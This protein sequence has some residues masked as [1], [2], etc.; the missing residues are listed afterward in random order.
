M[1]ELSKFRKL[2][3]WGFVEYME[4]S[5]AKKPECKVYLEFI[6]ELHLRSLNSVSEGGSYKIKKQA[7]A[8]FCDFQDRLKQGDFCQTAQQESFLQLAK[9]LGVE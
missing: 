5:L 2:D 6:E 4:M 8:L 3:W 1:R 7:G 9:D